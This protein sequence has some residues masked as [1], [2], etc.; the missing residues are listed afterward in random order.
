ME[1]RTNSPYPKKDRPILAAVGLLLIVSTVLFAWSDRKHDWRWYQ[2]EFRRQVTEKYGAEKAAG[3]PQGVQQ[4][5]VPDLRR[6]DRCVTCH[7]AS[8]WKGFETAEE[9][10]RTHPQEILKTHPVEKFGCTSCHGGQGWAIDAD[11]AHGPVEHWEEPVL[12]AALGEAYSLA[13]NK[14]ALLQMHCNTCH[15][16]DRET[17]GAEAI[18]LAKGLVIEKGCRACH[19]INGRGGTIG[20]DL[21]YVGDKAAEQYEYGRLS[22][23]KTAFA[24]HVAHFKDPRALVPDTVMPNFH[25]STKEAQALAMLTLSWRKAAVSADYRPGVPRTDPQTPEEVEAENRMKTGPGAWFV[26]TGCFVCHSVSA[27]GVKS[28]AQIGPDLSTAV[29]DTQARF[30]VTVDDFLD[31]P[32][33]TMAVVLSRQIILTPEQKKTAVAKLREAFAE[34]QKQQQARAAGTESAGDTALDKSKSK[35]ENE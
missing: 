21:T 2:F 25:L 12:G 1:K 29:E 31:R 7:Q 16:Y 33:G 30:G 28:P 34:H 32:T 4:V 9:P 3:L 24:W 10:F 11:E 26:Q 17:K 6:A 13:E 15:R 8:S 20:P 22:G 14:S 18:N 19:V 35:G 27:L 23:Q 5:W